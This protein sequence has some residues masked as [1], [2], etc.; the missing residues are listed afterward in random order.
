[1]KAETMTTTNRSSAFVSI[2]FDD[3]NVFEDDDGIG[4]RIPTEINSPRRGEAS[5][6]LLIMAYKITYP[7]R[8]LFLQQVERVGKQQVISWMESSSDEGINL[9]PPDALN[10]W[11]LN[12]EGETDEEED[13]S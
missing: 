6:N 4:I 2:I 3:A 1:M 7:T 12:I 8:D 9:P 10:S 13:E 11:V 5:M